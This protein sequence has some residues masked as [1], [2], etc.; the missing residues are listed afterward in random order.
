[1]VANVRR[2]RQGGTSTTSQPN[3]PRAQRSAASTR[4]T[5]VLDCAVLV[6]AGQTSIYY[7]PVRPRM[8]YSLYNQSGGCEEKAWARCGGWDGLQVRTSNNADAF[9]QPP[10]LLCADK[11]GCVQ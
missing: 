2:L 6:R 1:M 10:C 9:G 11:V 5:S 3:S 4:F 8:S 7:T